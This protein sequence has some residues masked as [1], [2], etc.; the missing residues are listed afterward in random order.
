MSASASSASQAAQAAAPSLVD[1]A[2]R[3]ERE[4]GLP[5]GAVQTD[6]LVACG[7]GRHLSADHVAACAE[8]F[9]EQT[10]PRAVVLVGEETR[11]MAEA[12]G[13]I[14][15]GRW[16]PWGSPWSADLLV[17]DGLGD[18]LVDL[19]A[20]ALFRPRT[21]APTLDRSQAASRAGGLLALLG[22][23]LGHRRK[24]PDAFNWVT[25]KTH[26]LTLRLVERHL[27]GDL[28]AG[29]FHP[30][31]AWQ[32]VVVDVDR[33]NALQAE[34]F[35]ETM[36]ALQQEFPNGIVVQSSASGGCHIYLRLP[37]GITYEEAALLVR[38]YLA[39]RNLLWLDS[40]G[41]RPL[42]T[43]RVE[44]P[45]EP[46][47]LPFGIGS[48]FVNDVRPIDVQV[49]DFCGQLASASSADFDKVRAA[50]H[51]ALGAV[52]AGRW[53]VVKVRRLKRK[54]AMAEVEDLAP[55]A[56][57]PNDLFALV[58]PRLPQYLQKVLA[59]GI[60]AYG[61]RTRWVTEVAA[62]LGSV[63]A[64]R[65]AADAIEH[66]LRKPGHVSADI[67]TELERVITEARLMS[68]RAARAQGIPIRIWA[69]VDR[70]VH[71]VHADIHDPVRRRAIEARRN[72][73]FTLSKPLSLEA[74]R[75]PA[76]RILW[77]FYNGRGRRPVRWRSISHR[78]FGRFSS[79]ALAHDVEVALTDGGWLTMIGGPAVGLH[80]RRY[81]LEDCAW[82]IR[83]NEPRVYQP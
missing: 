42:R 77:L 3:L 56:F 57:D 4:L 15:A 48:S 11:R 25:R 29:A 22:D 40:Q 83:P 35:D 45:T 50:V 16:E 7:L 72:R 2:L 52:L 47:R 70:L 34:S 44:V 63:L 41:P 51:L 13:L 82:P 58:A 71:Q 68:E 26:R 69:R 55:P 21:A 20:A 43:L 61:T 14:R 32:Y 12:A 75:K 62:Q 19:V 27:S 60:P 39:Q 1:A 10:A 37:D 81:R 31:G 73:D 59:H 49:A 17:V 6:H 36:A 18:A 46:P 79:G 24:T 23:H 30:Q 53:S 8:R 9:G 80:S 33:H 65:E 78:E 38:F 66:W 5:R 76:F 54:L 28:L 64:P 74:L 67:E